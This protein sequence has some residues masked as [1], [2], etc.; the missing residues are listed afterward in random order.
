MGDFIT[1]MFSASVN[2]TVSK[3]HVYELGFN[4]L[5]HRVRTCTSASTG[6]AYCNWK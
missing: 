5:E 1:N 3:F 6:R 4:G 2:R